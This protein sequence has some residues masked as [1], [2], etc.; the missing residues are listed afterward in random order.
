MPTY[1][2]IVF[3]NDKRFFTAV[4]LYRGVYS[5]IRPNHMLPNINYN[6]IY[7][8]PNRYLYTNYNII[9]G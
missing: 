7:S 9:I 5:E 8:K 4:K 2:T 6:N 1:N 3:F